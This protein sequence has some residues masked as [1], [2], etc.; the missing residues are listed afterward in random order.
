MNKRI[1]I[2]GIIL[3][4]LAGCKG[5]LDVQPKNFVASKNFYQNQEQVIS[6]VNGAYAELQTIYNS[7][8]SYLY[9]MSEMR[10]DNSTFQFDIQNRG[11]LQL[12]QIDEYLVSPDNNYINTTWNVLYGGIIQSNTILNRIENVEFSDES[13]KSRSIGEVKFLRG[14]LYFHL[15]RLFGEVPLVTREVTTPE[16]AFVDGKSS[17]DSIY[18]QIISDVQ[19]AAA[20][21]PESY[22]GS[23]VGRA[24]KGA[25]YTLLGNIYLTRQK[26]S[27][28]VTALQKVTDLG[29]SLL[30]EYS[31]VFNPS[32]KNNSEIIFSV[33]FN[34]GAEGEASNF[35]FEFTPL[36]APNVSK[37]FPFPSSGGGAGF[38][39]PTEGMIETYEKG[40]ERQAASIAYYTDP[41]TSQYSVAIGDSIPFIKKYYHPSTYPGP[42][43]GTENWPVYRYSHALLMLAEALNETGQTSQAYS[44][45]N[46]VRNRAGLDPLTSGLSQ[47]Q[48]REAL[49]HEMRVELAFENH[50]WFNLLRTNRAQQVMADHGEIRRE[51][52][53][54]LTDAAYNIQEYKLLFPIPQREVRLNN[55]EQNP[56]W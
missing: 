22:S 18:T 2:F 37:L 46:K 42:G 4:G 55:L 20:K 56:G 44:Y 16:E 45:I 49:Y 38:N 32:N 27:E 12:E 1:L 34:A 10:A 11:A 52:A 21:L 9:G 3:L 36:A 28:A 29:Y 17:I 25:A 15:V 54:R 5:F 39:I 14:L 50:R 19:D 23:N 13:I 47:S 33:Q 53:P 51:E 7:S 24:T 26:Y 40:D 6:A 30:P 41:E 31:D 43:R 8:S 35:A 48:F